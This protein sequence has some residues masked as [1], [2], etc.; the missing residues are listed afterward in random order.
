MSTETFKNKNN[1]NVY[2]KKCKHHGLTEYYV[3]NKKCVLCVNNRD[4]NKNH[5]EERNIKI[6][7]IVDYMG[8]KCVHCG[9][10]KCNRALDCHHLNPNEKE[11]AISEMYNRKWSFIEQEIKKCILLCANCHQN[12]H[13]EEEFLEN[14]MNKHRRKYRELLYKFN[15]LNCFICKNNNIINVAYHHIDPKTKEFTI[16]YGLSHGYSLK[17]LIEENKKCVVLCH[18]CHREYHSK[19]FHQDIKFISTLN[20]NKY[21]E[22]LQEE[23]DKKKQP[24]ECLNCGKLTFNNKFCSYECDNQYKKRNNPSK[25]E[26]KIL[27]QDN[28][29]DNIGKMFNVSGNAVKKWIKFYDLKY[30]PK[31]CKPPKKEYEPLLTKEELIKELE[32]L[33]IQKI[34]DK[35]KISWDKVKRNCDYYSLKSKHKNQYTCML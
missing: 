17:R 11:Y 7:R 24:K 5:I 33:S 10:N 23:Q 31:K 27:I 20:F 19:E 15:G 22:Y 29:L 21:I 32:N 12:I 26:L 28:T 34:A 30:I 25:E 3:S 4:K 14:S 13:N 16:S 6:Q 9:Y 35:Y 2:I 18:N 8:G 1:T